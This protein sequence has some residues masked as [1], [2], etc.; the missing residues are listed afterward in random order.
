MKSKKRRTKQL[1]KLIDMWAPLVRTETTHN[2]AVHHAA[3]LSALITTMLS[4]KY[5]L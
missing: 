5:P 3:H 1:R 2:Q 4:G